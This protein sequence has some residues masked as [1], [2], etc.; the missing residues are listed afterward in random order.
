VISSGIC[1]ACV[2]KSYNKEK[3]PHKFLAFVT[4]YLAPLFTA[5]GGM[6]LC[7]SLMVL[8]VLL[9][10]RH[11]AAAVFTCT[12]GSITV[13][14]LFVACTLIR[15]KTEAYAKNNGKPSTTVAQ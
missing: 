10:G 7:A 9:F 11:S 15:N 12:A 2:V 3:P 4:N 14:F 1:S 13:V 5:L 8:A 6:S